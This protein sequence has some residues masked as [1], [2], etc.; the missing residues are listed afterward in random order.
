MAKVPW[1]PF[2]RGWLLIC[3]ISSSTHDVPPGHSWVTNCSSRSYH[4]VAFV[5]SSRQKKHAKF[6]SLIHD[7]HSSQ[8]RKQQVQFQLGVKQFACCIQGPNSENRITTKLN[9]QRTQFWK[10]QLPLFLGVFKSAF[11]PF[12]SASV[13]RWQNNSETRFTS[14]KK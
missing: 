9:S 1:Y 13:C 8:N 14:D 12:I 6:W 5:S 11:F 3:K 2:L 7:V 10:S 4:L